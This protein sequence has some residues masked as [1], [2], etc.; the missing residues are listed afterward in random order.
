M[1][2]TITATQGTISEFET[3]VSALATLLSDD[4]PPAAFNRE[5]LAEVAR[6]CKF[7]PSYAEV[8]AVLSPWWRAHRPHVP[9]LPAPEPYR[10]R[11][12]TEEEIAG[13]SQTVREVTAALTQS[14]AERRA[15]YA[16]ASRALPLNRREMTRAELTEAYQRA[17]VKGPQPPK[18]PLLRAVMAHNDA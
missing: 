3:R 8:Y 11:I 6:A 4:F 12:W 16:Q 5:S 9:E 15:R 17:G 18:A 7:F 10:P 13:V 14:E 2:G 1:L